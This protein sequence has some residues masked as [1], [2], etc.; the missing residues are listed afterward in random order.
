[1]GHLLASVLLA[2][3]AGVITHMLSYEHPWPL[4]A[5][6]IVFLFYWGAV[7]LVFDADW[8]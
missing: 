5:G 4:I 7:V 2:V 1:M 3:C 8:F 6:V